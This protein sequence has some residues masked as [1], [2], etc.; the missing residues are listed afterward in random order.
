MWSFI[1][2]KSLFI[3]FFLLYKYY[4]YIYFVK[5]ILLGANKDMELN[6]RKR[7]A[8][9]FKVFDNGYLLAHFLAAIFNALT[10]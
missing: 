9:F 4:I 8:D 7:S 1:C 10:L 3:L 5:L 6:Q 2:Y